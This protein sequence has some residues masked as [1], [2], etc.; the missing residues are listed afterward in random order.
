MSALPDEP[1]L[2]GFEATRSSL[3]A[4]VD[5]LDAARQEAADGRY[6]D[7]MLAIGQT[8]LARI[9]EADAGMN[10]VVER[11]GALGGASRFPV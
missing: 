1:L 3:E 11:L 7:A 4:A 2:H 5:A 8:V 10:D 9:Q 6:C